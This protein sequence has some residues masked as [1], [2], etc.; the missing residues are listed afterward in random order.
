MKTVTIKIKKAKD[1][2]RLYNVSINGKEIGYEVNGS[3]S[4]TL[5]KEII[6]LIKNELDTLQGLD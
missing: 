1:A 3:F 4:G 6:D 5:T 2:K